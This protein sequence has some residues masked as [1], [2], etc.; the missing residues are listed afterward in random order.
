MATR[1]SILAWENPWTED[2]GELQ[3]WGPKRFGH[4]L[5]TKQQQLCKAI[6]VE[7]RIYTKIVAMYS[8]TQFSLYTFPKFS[9]IC[10]H[11]FIYMHVYVCI[12]IYIYICIYTLRRKQQLELDMEQQIG[13]KL[14]KESRLCIVILLL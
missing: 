7:G 10:I 11:T 14:G 9:T 12:Y 2:P 8:D 5:A 13:S 3:S 4:N 6:Y 1:S